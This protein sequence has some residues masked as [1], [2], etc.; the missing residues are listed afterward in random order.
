MAKKAPVLIAVHSKPESDCRLSD[1]RDYFLFDTGLAVVNLLTQATQMGL[2]A[3]PVAGYDP[4]GF[5]GI[6]NIPDED[7]LITV[8]G[9][10][11]PADVD[12]LS[13]KHQ[14]IENSPRDRIDLGKI[15]NWNGYRKD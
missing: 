14:I 12:Y 4:E 5:K 6:L 15:L 8:I 7:V 13:E 1:S 11:F 3:H 10:G 9:I 2:I